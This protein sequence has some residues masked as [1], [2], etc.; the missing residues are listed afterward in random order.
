MQIKY[1]VQTSDPLKRYLKDHAEEYTEALP[2]VGEDLRLCIVI[3]SLAERENIGA[4]LDSLPEKDGRFE[5]IVVV[6]HKEGASEEVVENNAGTVRD[7]SGR[8]LVIE[9]TFPAD[10]GCQQ[11]V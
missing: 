11:M 4:V 2:P 5:V 8:A 10:I 1:K 7:V 6:N 9:R 3:P